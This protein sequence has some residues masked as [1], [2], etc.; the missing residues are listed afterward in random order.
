MAAAWPSRFRVNLKETVPAAPLL[1]VLQTHSWSRE[2]VGS[3]LRWGGLGKRPLWPLLS[4]LTYF[5]LALQAPCLLLPPAWAPQTCPLGP[6]CPPAEA[7]PRLPPGRSCPLAAVGVSLGL[8]WPAVL[9]EGP[10][11]PARPRPRPPPRGG[12]A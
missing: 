10:S 8:S 9:P 11:A 1:F 4:P 12:Q 3:G 2:T 5:L 6:A 7:T